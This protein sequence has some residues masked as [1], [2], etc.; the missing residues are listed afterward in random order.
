MS[1]RTLLP[2]VVAATALALLGYVVLASGSGSRDLPVAAPAGPAVAPTAPAEPAPAM[3]PAA[4]QGRSLGATVSSDWLSATAAKAGIPAPALR[5]Y[6]TA[7]LRLAGDDAG[8]HL[9][10]T[11]LAGIGWVESQHGTFGG[12]T[13][14]EDGV[15]SAP[16]LGPTLDGSAGVA[17]IPTDQGEWAQAAGPMQFIPSTWSGWASDGDG[18]GVTNVQDLDDAAYA[19]GRYLCASGPLSSGAGWAKAVFSYNH[20]QAYVDQVY[21]AAQVYAQRTASV[22]E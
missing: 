15:P 9:G 18:D 19:A 10:W 3:S 6:A 21:A 13:L 2:P 14:G 22:V 1:L 17:A 20:S 16:I 5:G 7:Q 8:C 12:R 4:A 11:T